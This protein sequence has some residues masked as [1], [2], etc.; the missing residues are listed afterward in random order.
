MGDRVAIEIRR[1][2]APR[3]VAVP[4]DLAAALALE[5]QLRAAFDAM[6]YTH[7][8]EWVEALEDAKRP[9]TRA[10]R[11]AQA[12]QAARATRDARRMGAG[13]RR[14]GPGDLDALT[15]IMATAF[16]NDPVWGEYSYPGSRERLDTAATVWRAY[17]SALIRHGWSFLSPGGESAAVWVP[18]GERELTDEQERELEALLHAL[19][20]DAQAAI[21]LDAF[22]RLDAAHPLHEPHHHLSL[23]GTH[24]DHRGRGIGMALLDACLKRVDAAGTPAY[25][26]STNPANDRRY[27]S[28]GF[29]PFGRVELAGGPV[30]TTMWRPARPSA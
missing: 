27:M 24:E 6:S 8:R 15:A 10:K 16:R 1:D 22:A 13:L 9:E 12:V 4:D 29:E 25:L 19:L 21:V 18:P 2:E 30:V 28:R 3:T 5:P 26:E 23:F 17:L 14:A 7:R 11:I 20:G